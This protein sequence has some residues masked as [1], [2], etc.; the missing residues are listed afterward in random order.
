LADCSFVS[1][2]GISACVHFAQRWA[3]TAGDI[4]GLG[5]LAV[6]GLLVAYMRHIRRR[7]TIER[8][9]SLER[10]HRAT[11]AEAAQLQFDARIHERDATILANNDEL[12]SLNEKFALA[13]SAVEANA[14]AAERNANALEIS[15]SGDTTFWTQPPLPLKDTGLPLDL[16]LECPV[17]L[18]ANQK[19]GVGKTSAVASLAAYYASLGQNVLT[20]DLDY[21]GSLTNLMRLEQFGPPGNPPFQP[22]RDIKSVLGGPFHRSDW[23]GTTLD[24]IVNTAAD[25]FPFAEEPLKG[26]LYYISTDYELAQVERREEYAWVLKESAD[27]PRYRLAA[28]L[29]LAQSN[30]DLDYILLDAP[31]RFSMGFINGLCAASHLFV[32]TV[33]DGTSIRAV[34]TFSIQFRD[35]QRALNPSLDWG[36]IIGMMTT[37]N[38]SQRNTLPNTLVPAAQSAEYAARNRLGPEIGGF[39]FDA[40]VPRSSNISEATLTGIPFLQSEAVRKAGTFQN[41][42]N[43]ILRRVIGHEKDAT[44]TS[45]AGA[46]AMHAG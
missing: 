5:S 11:N 6:V 21:Q 8:V 27:D 40:I 34:E 42:G 18:F 38:P 1:P 46:R 41:L 29:K 36:G 10:L 45:A 37:E 23:I 16:T 26:N 25:Q 43:A 33:V 17:L 4:I 20:I 14:G 39:F 2:E 32:P 12:R 24:D 22:R 7:L 35:V 9:T 28:F 3:Q 15:S 31:P 19:G 44:G 13:K 30:F